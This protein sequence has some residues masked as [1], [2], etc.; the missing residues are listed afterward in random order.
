MK[1]L[2]VDGFDF[3]KEL[4][5]EIWIS[6]SNINTDIKKIL[7]KIVEKFI[8][9]LK[10][11]I[12]EYDIRLTGSI[13]N[14][15]W[16]K[17]S[18]IDLH[19]QT[20]FS[21]IDDD[22]ELVR[23]YFSSVCALW[24]LKH[25]I[26]IKG[27]DVEIY[28]EDSNEVHRSTGVYSISTEEWITEPATEQ[29]EEID[30]DAVRKKSKN[31]AMQIAEL[32]KI[33]DQ[34]EVLKLSEKIREKIRRMRKSGLET[35]KSQYSTGN[36]AFK[37]LRRN[38]LLDKLADIKNK[39]YDSTMSIKENSSIKSLKQILNKIIT[40][41]LNTKECSGWH[42][43]KERDIVYK[44]AKI[45]GTSIGEGSSKDYA[46]NTLENISEWAISKIRNKRIKGISGSIEEYKKRIIDGLIPK[47]VAGSYMNYISGTLKLG[48][49]IA[50][51]SDRGDLQKPGTSKSE[52][53]WKSELEKL[54][55]QTKISYQGPKKRS[56]RPDK[57]GEEET[58]GEVQLDSDNPIP[59]NK[60]DAVKYAREQGAPHLAFPDGDPNKRSEQSINWPM[61]GR[62]N[63]EILLNLAD[64]IDRAKDSAKEK[65]IKTVQSEQLGRNIGTDMGVFDR[66]EK[67]Q[68]AFM[69]LWKEKISPEIV[70]RVE[71]FQIYTFSDVLREFAIGDGKYTRKIVF[72]E[73]AKGVMTLVKDVASDAWE[74]EGL[75]DT[76]AELKAAGNKI[77]TFL[78]VKS[79]TFD[80]MVAKIEQS[81]GTIAKMAFDGKIFDPD[82]GLNG[83][84]TPFG[85]G[86]NAPMKAKEA[87][88][89]D[90]PTFTGIERLMVHELD[91]IVYG[92]IWGLTALIQGDYHGV[93]HGGGDQFVDLV[94]SLF[95][96]PSG[97]EYARSAMLAKFPRS[98][99]LPNPAD[100]FDTRFKR[101]TK[102]IDM[103]IWE[104]PKHAFEV[105][106]KR[107]PSELT[108]DTTSKGP[109]E[110]WWDYVFRIKAPE[111]GQSLPSKKQATD[112]AGNPFIGDKST[113]KP[114][115][116]GGWVYMFGDGS[117]AGG[118]GLKGSKG[119]LR[120]DASQGKGFHYISPQ[121]A[122]TAG[123]IDA[124]VVVTKNQM[125]EIGKEKGFS[126]RYNLTPED[127]RKLASMTYKEIKDAG[128]SNNVAQTARI[129]KPAS[130]IDNKVADAFN[131]TGG[132]DED[133]VADDLYARVDE[134]TR[135][136]KISDLKIAIRN[137]IKY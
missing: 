100:V 84:A 21:K 17:Y 114:V 80:G 105:L 23:G 136:S 15:N 53:S 124:R 85:F 5:P 111:G 87:I 54:I 43:C 134:A 69:D 76:I 96:A 61:N 22:I 13:A 29:L 113:S 33:K 8:D 94:Q 77:T 45:T 122:S 20:D 14:Y 58:R 74:A 56:G 24:N 34:K 83:M 90:P 52:Q 10:V 59:M 72:K 116:D 107:E 11:E 9:G 6:N 92:L 18:D 50:K 71:E 101:N 48:I 75:D 30:I 41:N 36:I 78:D 89:G 98:R 4:E 2:S 40:E 108:K 70:K 26:K 125:K 119:Y 95:G 27:Y 91:H 120:G 86:I 55:S 127:L 47:K 67:Y 109:I 35:K 82:D 64:M 38:G 39:S 12:E 121:N 99:R 97:A 46:K 63:R 117:A 28:I 110:I 73:D 112:T 135:K 51:Y 31:I 137:A 133:P 37:V 115:T 118:P 93:S 132:S 129:L 103:K 123:E 44:L 106:S 65:T 60:E 88:I 126:G 81:A 49:A 130:E 66:S 62:G 16:S 7:V 32:E 104:D 19:I 3:K 42:T 79:T 128:F 1:K 131:G 68:R 102:W 25:D 57:D